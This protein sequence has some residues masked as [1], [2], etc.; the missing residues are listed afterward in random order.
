M[1]QYLDSALMVSGP[2]SGLRLKSCAII[3]LYACREGL[4]EVECEI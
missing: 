4:E 1:S 3:W 2:R